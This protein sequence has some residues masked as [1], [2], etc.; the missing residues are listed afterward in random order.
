MNTFSLLCAADMFVYT[1]I[2]KGRLLVV[3]TVAN[4]LK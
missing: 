4:Y 3:N 2:S 1:A